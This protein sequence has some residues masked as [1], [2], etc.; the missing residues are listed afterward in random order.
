MTAAQQDNA[1]QVTGLA[2]LEARLHQDLSWL[3]L[4]AKHWT[5]PHTLEGRSVLDVAV[6]G[7]GMAGL[8]AAASLK[9]LGIGVMVF[10]RSPAG[11]E[12]PW[13]TTARMET[14]RSPKQLTGPAL[15]LPALTFR[16]WFEA[17]FGTD[18]WEVLDKIPRLQWMDY[19]RW[20]RRVLQLDVRN[21]HHVKAIHPRVDGAVELLIDAP[22]QP[23]QRVFARRV[24]LATGRD[25]LGGASVPDFARRL[26][27]RWWAHSSDEMDYGALA[28]K[29][30]GVIGAGASAM[31]SAATA[32]EAGAASV[33]MLIRRADLPRVNK[34]KGAGS[35]GLVHG[36][37]YLPDA[38]KWRIR[39]YINVEQVPRRAAARC[40]CRG[41]R[42]RASISAA[43]FWAWTSTTACCTWPRPRAYSNW[44]S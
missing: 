41:I 33:D 16:A 2:A 1:L 21:E 7:G 26:P 35:P 43:A 4:P 11:F 8:A 17:Q 27:R 25:G 36:H 5:L 19:L 30:V 37:L 6:I 10:D 22:D 15:G 32:L 31:D 40:V 29:R 23:T 9:H 24:V 3:E 12:G 39:H 28:G 34:G 44:T 20:Y 38:W 18:A 42:M 13:A 14:L